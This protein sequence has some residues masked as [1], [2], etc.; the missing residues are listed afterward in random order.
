MNSTRLLVAVVALALCSAAA[1]AAP[2]PAAKNA[3]D[4]NAGFGAMRDF[5]LIVLKDLQSSQGVQGRTFVGG[6]LTG[7][8][9]NYY[10]KPGSQTGTALIVGGDVTGGSKNIQNG[11]SIEVGGNLEAG[12]NMNGGGSV[13]VDGNVKKVNANGASVYANG[14]VENTNAKDIYYSGAIK[15]SNGARHPGDKSAAGLEDAIAA[16][17]AAYTE[18]LLATSEY[19]ATLTPTNA[20]SYSSNGQQAIFDAGK[21]AGVAVFALSDLKGALSGRSQLV[22]NT[23][24]GYDLI[25]INVAGQDVSLPSSINFNGPAG[26]GANVIWNFYQAST[27]NLGSK[28]WYG[29]VL[30]PNAQLRINNFI[31]GSV[32]ARSLVQNGEIRMGNFQARPTVY[33]PSGGF[34]GAVPEP[35]TWAMMILGFGVIGAVLRRRRTATAGA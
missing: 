17:A 4:I 9:S 29:S 7:G 21:G 13:R 30:A 20:I 5:N 12:A 25:V 31:E 24:V 11:G 32:V 3:Q 22:F 27:V 6:N 35:G 33:A 14:N 19:L 15:S 18:D 10:T 8:S 2:L 16:Q 26:L 1:V 28:S 23:P 34:S